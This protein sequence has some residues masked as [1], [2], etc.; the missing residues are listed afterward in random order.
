MENILN[1][2]LVGAIVGGVFAFITGIVLNKVE[3][4]NKKRLKFL[5]FYTI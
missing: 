4:V 5:F 1:S 2:S 3:D